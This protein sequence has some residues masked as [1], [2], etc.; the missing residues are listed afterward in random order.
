MY[1]NFTLLASVGLNF[2]ETESFVLLALPLV[3]FSKVSP[4]KV[5]DTYISNSSANPLALGEVY[6]TLSIVSNL[7]KV[8]ITSLV[9]FSLFLS[10]EC[11]AVSTSPSIALVITSLE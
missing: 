1:T 8:I 4:S 10:F 11:Q 9:W 2:I 6:T 7:S 5:L 3:T